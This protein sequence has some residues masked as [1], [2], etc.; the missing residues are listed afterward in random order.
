MSQAADDRNESIAVREATATDVETRI[1]PD[2]AVRDVTAADFQ[3]APEG[4]PD[5]DGRYETWF[6]Y[7]AA[8]YLEALRPNYSDEHE[9][10]PG[11]LWARMRDRNWADAVRDAAQPATL[12]DTIVELAIWRWYTGAND[13]G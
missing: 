12:E 13:D 5:R 7:G 8:H 9:S 11:T 6:R 3:A 10:F 2:S 4:A 1:V